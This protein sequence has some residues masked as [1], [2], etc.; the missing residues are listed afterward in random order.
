MRTLWEYEPKL[1]VLGL[2]VLL[3]TALL[4]LGYLK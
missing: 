2:I 3:S 1:G 4:T